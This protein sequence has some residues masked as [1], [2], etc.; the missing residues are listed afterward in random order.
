MFSGPPLPL[1]PDFPLHR[2]VSLIGCSDEVG[3]WIRDARPQR[4]LITATGRCIA[5]MLGGDLGAL[6]RCCRRLVVRSHSQALVL[7]ADEII[8][9]RVLQVITGTPYLPSAERLTGIF[10]EAEMDDVGFHIPIPKCLPEEVLANCLTH[11]IRVMG[12]RIVY[13]APCLRVDSTASDCTHTS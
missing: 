3:V 10:P 1:P 9:W 4:L 5:V 6:L 2:L 7:E 13:R 11:G 8:R 12:S